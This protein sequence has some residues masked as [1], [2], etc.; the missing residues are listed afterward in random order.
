MRGYGTLQGGGFNT[1]KGTLLKVSQAIFM[2]HMCWSIALLHIHTPY[3][4]LLGFQ[5]EVYNRLG[6]G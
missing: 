1:H 4:T 5:R 3:V 6:E 2:L